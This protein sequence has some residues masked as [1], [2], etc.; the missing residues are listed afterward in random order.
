MLIHLKSHNDIHKMLLN[1]NLS[2]SPVKLD[3]PT[4]NHK[5][6]V[7]LIFWEYK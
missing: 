4:D 7:I 1:H 3:S 2:M 5:M 6:Q